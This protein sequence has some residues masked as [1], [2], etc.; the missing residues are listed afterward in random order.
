M[1]ILF[2]FTTIAVI[3]CATSAQTASIKVAYDQSALKS[4]SDTK[5]NTCKM[6]LLS[7]YE[8]SKYYNEISEYCDSMTSTPSGK[9]K[10]TE[11]QMA[12]WVSHGADG[13]INVDLSKGNAPRKTIHTYITKNFPDGSMRVYDRWGDENG[14][15]DEPLSEQVWTISDDST[16]TI[17]GY[18]CIMASTDY[19]GRHWTA[20]FTPDIPVQDGPWKLHGLPGLILMAESSPAF[21]FEATGIEHTDKTINPVYNQDTYSRVNRKKALADA[22]YFDTNRESIIRAKYGATF[23]KNSDNHNEIIFDPTR[24]AFETDYK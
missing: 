24:H 20:W 13:S 7:G 17:L 14:F 23:I 3:A 8:G 16:R 9:K 10:L 19:H 11:I 21:R 15:Y 5:I 18:N 1:R 6:L 12:A 4:G 22:E 2:F